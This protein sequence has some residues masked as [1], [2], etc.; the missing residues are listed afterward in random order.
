[1]SSPRKGFGAAPR[2]WT[3]RLHDSAGPVASFQVAAIDGQPLTPKAASRT[4]ALV[5]SLL[6]EPFNPGCRLRLLTV[7][8]APD[9]MALVRLSRELDPVFWVD[10]IAPHRRRVGQGHS[11][12]SGSLPS[13]RQEG[14]IRRVNPER[15]GRVG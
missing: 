11:Q 1:M 7:L 4:V 6:Q 14:R 5:V 8:S 3:F 12:A 13:T 10:A 15:L 2:P 9:V